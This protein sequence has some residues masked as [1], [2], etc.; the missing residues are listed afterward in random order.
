MECE[1]KALP[2]L[3]LLL[4]M[5]EAT[6][7]RQPVTLVS[8]CFPADASLDAS[9]PVPASTVPASPV[10]LEQERG[11]RCAKSAEE[12]LP[13]QENLWCRWSQSLAY[14]FSW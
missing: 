1:R 8:S 9:I 5:K 14:A 10:P 6:G 4:R 12:L 11:T 2:M 7:A 3:A 13:Q